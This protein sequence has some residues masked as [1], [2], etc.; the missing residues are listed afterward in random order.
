MTRHHE[1]KQKQIIY[2]LALIFFAQVFGLEA[3]QA[4][5]SSPAASI[6]S[7]D[8]QGGSFNFC[9]GT[10]WLSLTSVTTDVNG[11]VGIGTT[12]PQAGLDL[13]TLGTL[14]SAVIVPRDTTSNRPTPPVNGMIRYNTTTGLFEGYESG[15]WI[16]LT[17]G[18]VGGLSLVGKA[19]CNWTIG[20]SWGTPTANSNCN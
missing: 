15:A 8:F 9:D 11:N 12:V 20:T 6:G 18:Y 7:L 1:I 10:N 5:C 19:N 4:A 3:A 2:A 17:T 13:A 16:N 14:G